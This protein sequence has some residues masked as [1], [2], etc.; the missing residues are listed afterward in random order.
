[1]IFENCIYLDEILYRA[2]YKGTVKGR[3]HVPVIGFSDDFFVQENFI[4][5]CNSDNVL[6]GL[7][8]H[9]I[10]M[11]IITSCRRTGS[12]PDCITVV[13]S[14]NALELFDRCIDASYNRTIS[15]LKVGDNCIIH[16]SV[17]FGNNVIIED[18]CSI[19]ANVVVGDN[20]VI[21]NGAIIEPNSVIGSFPFSNYHGVGAYNRHIYGGVVIGSNT[22]IGSC[23]TI[24]RGFTIDTQIGS[25]C[26]IGN[27]VEIS[28]DVII[29]N[30]CY[31][32]AQSA[33]AGNVI[34][35][36]N[37]YMWAKSGI[38]N[39]IHV[40]DGTVLYATSVMTKDSKEG[41]KLCGFPAVK[42]ETYWRQQAII[43][44][45]CMQSL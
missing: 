35:G 3:V 36:N 34:M 8:K 44:Q 40:A 11:V 2:H 4:T 10:P 19:G 18:N 17:V 24:D 16:D 13:P 45:I 28:H 30:N 5:W 6:A 20:S 14:D 38:D 32:T 43:K 41:D 23:T 37:C 39:R 12:I 15:K 1:M 42:K 31:I 27:L 33:I 22:H 29:G 21:C 26:K 9:H 7:L 25:G